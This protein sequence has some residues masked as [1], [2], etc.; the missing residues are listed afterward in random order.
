VNGHI[1]PSTARSRWLTDAIGSNWR[2]IKTTT[3]SL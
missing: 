1:D 2:G 3:A